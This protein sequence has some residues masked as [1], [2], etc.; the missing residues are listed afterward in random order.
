LK[1]GEG[2]LEGE[3]REEKEEKKVRKQAESGPPPKNTQTFPWNRDSSG[4]NASTLLGIDI[5]FTF[6]SLILIHSTLSTL[7]RLSTIIFYYTMSVIRYNVNTVVYYVLSYCVL[8]Y[9]YP[10]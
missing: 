7:S 10:A 9:K 1:V 5:N 2:S 3:E 8:Y 4:G 6:H